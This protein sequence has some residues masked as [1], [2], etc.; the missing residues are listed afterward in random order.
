MANQQKDPPNPPPGPPVFTDWIWALYDYIRQNLMML[1]G[2]GIAITDTGSGRSINI[3]SLI[4]GKKSVATPF[5][6]AIRSKPN[7]PN[8]FQFSVGFGVLNQTLTPSDTATVTGVPTTDDGKGLTWYDLTETDECVYIN[9]ES[10]DLSMFPGGGE[11]YK[12]NSKS[13]GGSFNPGTDAWASANAF[14]SGNDDPDIPGVT[15]QDEFCYPLAY[16]TKGTDGTYTVQQ[17]CLTNLKISNFII[18]GSPAVYPE[19]GI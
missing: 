10:I 5:A 16:I 13:Q 7:S 1:E 2:V 4:S 8:A 19:P 3:A 9:C 15:D 12:I 6:V 17:Q 14:V 18:L 11:T